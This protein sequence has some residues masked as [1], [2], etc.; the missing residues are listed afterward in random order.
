[1]LSYTLKVAL[2]LMEDLR[3]YLDQNIWSED[4]LGS[5]MAYE[6]A[7]SPLSYPVAFWD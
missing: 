7:Y 4:M 3:K 1:M 2:K 6:L 5:M